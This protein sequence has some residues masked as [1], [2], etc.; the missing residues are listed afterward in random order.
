LEVG[1][2]GVSPARIQAGRLFYPNILLLGTP[3]Y[4]GLVLLQ[5]L[6]SLNEKKIKNSISRL[7]V[8]E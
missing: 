7:T 4:A 3:S 2:A 6:F 5:L 8:V 1:K